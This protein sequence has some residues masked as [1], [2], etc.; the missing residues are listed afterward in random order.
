[1]GS[2]EAIGAQD[3]ELA[4]WVMGSPLPNFSLTVGFLLPMPVLHLVRVLHWQVY[5]LRKEAGSLKPVLK[6]PQL[7]NH[8][9]VRCCWGSKSGRSSF[10]ARE[11]QD[12]NV[13]LWIE[14]YLL[15]SSDSEIWGTWRQSR[16]L[17][18]GLQRKF[19]CK[20]EIQVLVSLEGYTRWRHMDNRRCLP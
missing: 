13:T 11:S 18:R 1:M 20:K 10:R 9:Q 12:L 19:T 15:S 14:R 7:A 6:L 5:I 2:S 3:S 17:S 16:P 8:I 4:H